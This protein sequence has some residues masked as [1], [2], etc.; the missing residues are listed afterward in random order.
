MIKE[1]EGEAQQMLSRGKNITHEYTLPHNSKIFI[2][3]VQYKRSLALT[4]SVCMSVCNYSV[5]FLGE[6]LSHHAHH[7]VRFMTGRQ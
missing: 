2:L 3:L 1:S 4:F 6:K 5:I 7:R